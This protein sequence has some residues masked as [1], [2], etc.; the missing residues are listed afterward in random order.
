MRDDKS[1]FIYNDFEETDLYW[2]IP[3]IIRLAKKKKIN[4][5]FTYNSIIS[6]LEK[7][8]FF[9]KKEILLKDITKEL[10]FYFGVFF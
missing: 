9:Q 5:V 3:I 8:E 6:I 1:I 7:D 10:P 2:I 4:K